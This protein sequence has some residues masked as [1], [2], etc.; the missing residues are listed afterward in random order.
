MVKT[1]LD[2]ECLVFKLWLENRAGRLSYDLNTGP[3]SNDINRASKSCDFSAVFKWHS[4]SNSSVYRTMNNL[5]FGVAVIQI[6]TE[7]AFKRAQ[8]TSTY[9]I[10]VV[11]YLCKVF[12]RIPYDVFETK[13]TSRD[14]MLSPTSFVCFLILWPLVIPFTTM[15][16]DIVSKNLQVMQKKKIQS[17][18]AN[19]IRL[20]FLIIIL[21]R[22]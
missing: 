20:L 8:S 12:Q 2:I 15:C 7:L 21:C 17:G 10:S 9:M 18:C 3:N 4:K 6:P 13:V 1:S 5:D 16:N 22:R 19:N 14:S 11:P